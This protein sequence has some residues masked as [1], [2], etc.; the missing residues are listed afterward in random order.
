MIDRAKRQQ[1]SL[2]LP[3]KIKKNVA[4]ENYS[5]VSVYG[6]DGRVSECGVNCE[7]VRKGGEGLK[8]E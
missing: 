1:R 6:M 8:F 3:G 2:S 4:D 5:G 7:V